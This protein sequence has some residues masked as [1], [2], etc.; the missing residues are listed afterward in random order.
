MSRVLDCRY[1]FYSN[2]ILLSPIMI[3]TYMKLLV[4]HAT[5]NIYGKIFLTYY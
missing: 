3:G 1:C 4:E 5:A 2:Y